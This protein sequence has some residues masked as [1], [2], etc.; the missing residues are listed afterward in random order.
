[1]RMAEGDFKLASYVLF[2]VILSNCAQLGHA[3]NAEG[4][5][6]VQDHWNLQN[7]QSD[8]SLNQSESNSSSES[9]DPVT[10]AVRARSFTYLGVFWTKVFFFVATKTCCDIRSAD[11]KLLGRSISLSLVNVDLFQFSFQLKME[12]PVKIPLNCLQQQSKQISKRGYSSYCSLNDISGGSRH[13]GD[14][15]HHA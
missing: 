2:S 13:L 6:V 8:H 15:Y 3:V 7:R 5:V 4:P 1:M 11:P 12:T 9:F 14:I 10:T